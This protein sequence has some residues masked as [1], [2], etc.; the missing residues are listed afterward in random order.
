MS[1]GTTRERQWRRQVVSV[2]LRGRRLPGRM[3]AWRLALSRWRGAAVRGGGWLAEFTCYVAV[4]AVAEAELDVVA[5]VDSVRAVAAVDQ[6]GLFERGFGA[7][8]AGLRAETG[9]GIAL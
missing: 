8:P 7:G 3:S 4:V 1:A 6:A 5:D 2:A 9:V